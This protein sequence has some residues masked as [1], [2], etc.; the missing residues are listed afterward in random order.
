MSAADAGAIVVPLAFITTGVAKAVVA[1]VRV[2]TRGFVRRIVTV[3]CSGLMLVAVSRCLEVRGVL[4]SE[5]TEL[6]LRSTLT[7][8]YFLQC[9]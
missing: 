7:Y 8:S 6:L 4:D 1:R 2:A 3:A 5:G 9:L